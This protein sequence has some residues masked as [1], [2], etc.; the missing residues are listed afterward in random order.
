M[1]G[2]CP[3]NKRGWQLPEWHQKRDVVKLRKEWY[4]KLKDDGFYDCE[5]G[6]EGHLLLG[7]TPSR[8]F[9][10]IK[11][12]MDGLRSKKTDVHHVLGLEDELVNFMDSSK[13]NYHHW[14]S[15]IV[16]QAFRTRE[17]VEDCWIWMLHTQ[18]VGEQG[19]AKELGY[20]WTKVHRSIQVLK[21]AIGSRLT[22]G[23]G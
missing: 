2:W 23:K 17:P 19:I 10:V 5:G 1:T 3:M 18:G 7:P 8:R 12:E 22:L 21:G 14:A 4:A 13:A 16:A 6:V 20:S 11:Q 15:L 9:Y